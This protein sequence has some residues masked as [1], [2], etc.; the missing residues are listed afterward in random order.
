SPTRT[1][2]R[3]IPFEA[4]NCGVAAFGVPI[5]FPLL[6]RAA[7]DHCRAHR[8][9]GRLVNHDQTACRSIAL[10]RIE[11]EGRGGA[12]RRVTNLIEPECLCRGVAGKRVDLEPVV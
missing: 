3:A 2:L 6:L 8:R 4:A 7:I 9:A 10:V 11:D 5:V 12:K 1:Y